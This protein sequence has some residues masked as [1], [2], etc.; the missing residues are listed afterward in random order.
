MNCYCFFLNFFNS[1][2]CFC[3]SYHSLLLLFSL[4][5]PL[6]LDF[7]FS[8]W[9]FCLFAV[10][11]LTFLVNFFHAFFLF[12]CLVSFY[13]LLLSLVISLSIVATMFFSISPSA[14]SEFCFSYFLLFSLPFF[15]L[16]FFCFS[17]SSLILLLLFSLLF[18]VSSILFSVPFTL[19]AYCL[20]SFFPFLS[21]FT[22]TF[23]F[24]S[25]LLP[26]FPIYYLLLP[27][28]HFCHF[29]FLLTYYYIRF[30]FRFLLFSHLLLC[31]LLYLFPCITVYFFS[32][33]SFFVLCT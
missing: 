17:F 6:S 28:V 9:F 27:V 26:S 12:L 18:V 2:S 21:Y 19:F 30:L 32:P 13:P 10:A 24:Y 8:R 5:S 7:Y 1:H 25:S 33:P 29:F 3:L 11:F 23:H 31:L 4:F 22:D 14:S 15:L 20:S 16:V